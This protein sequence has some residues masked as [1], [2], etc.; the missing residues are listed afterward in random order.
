MI[1]NIYF[2]YR[3][4]KYLSSQKY[5]IVMTLKQEVPSYLESIFGGYMNGLQ[6]FSHQSL[7]PQ[8]FCPHVTSPLDFISTFDPPQNFKIYFKYV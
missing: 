2:H 4:V 8:L 3:R 1:T 5:E 6:S 7:S